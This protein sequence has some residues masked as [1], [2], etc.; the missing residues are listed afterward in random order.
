VPELPEIHALVSDL[1]SRLTGR[2]VDRLDVVSFAALKTV[3]PP[4]SALSGRVIGRLA[5]HG[6]FLDI[7]IGDLH[8]V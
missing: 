6:K 8:L 1:G 3:D 7:A 2:T 5:R 4:V